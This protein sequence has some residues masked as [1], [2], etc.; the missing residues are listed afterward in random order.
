[1]NIWE[2]KQKKL[3][4]IL[5]KYWGYDSLKSKQ[6]DIISN[7]I[8]GKDV[9]GL[10][11]T[12]YGKSMCYLIPPLLTKKTIFIIS[13]LISLMED[14]KEKLLKKGIPVSALHGNNSNKDR[15]VFDIIDGKIKIVYMSPEYLIKGDGLELAKKLVEENMLGYFAVDESHCISV[16]GHDFRVHYLQL[17]KFR[18][19]FDNI[20]LLALT[21]TA[22]KAVIDDIEKYLNMRDRLL[23]TADF[24]RPN[25]YI[26]CVDVNFENKYRNKLNVFCLDGKLHKFDDNK[27]CKRCNICPF[28]YQ[29]TDKDLDLYTIEDTYKRGKNKGKIKLITKVGFEDKIKEQKKILRQKIKKEKDFIKKKRLESDLDKYLEYNENVGYYDLMKPYLDKYN[30]D[31]IIIYANSRKDCVEISNQLNEKYNSITKEYS[32]AYHAGMTKKLREQIQK[33]F[34]SG[35]VKVIV[36]TIAFGMGI[37]Q[38][39]RCVLIFGASSSIEEYYQQIG[40]AGRD[41]KEAETILFYEMQKM[42]VNKQLA[43][44]ET[45]NPELRRVKVENINNVMNLCNTKICRRRFILEYFRERTP[46]FFCCNNCDNCCE[47]DLLDY[48]KKVWNVCFKNKKV[49]DTFKDKDIKIFKESNLLRG[50]STYTLSNYLIFWKKY[51]EFKEYKSYKKIPESLRICL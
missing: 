24:D 9:I 3:N 29:F 38:I 25:L 22:T 36:S 19:Y 30:E 13:P 11:P 37:D 4:K 8:N 27:I 17:Y 7:F 31:R 45:K 5:M 28:N 35:K 15:E 12:G 44:K 18:K 20:P 34:S 41:G 40:R 10:L 46:K 23:F 51:V 32:C 47:R 26:K 43:I 42:V 2:K 49:N 14:Q 21:A 6:I 33:K 48:T 1:M 16:W 39:V 50:N